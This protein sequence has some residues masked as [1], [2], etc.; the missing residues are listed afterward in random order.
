MGWVPIFVTI[1]VRGLINIRW[2]VWIK[3]RYDFFVFEGVVLALKVKL[4][5]EGI[6]L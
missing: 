2:V 4:I 6:L 5:N 3:M 1:F